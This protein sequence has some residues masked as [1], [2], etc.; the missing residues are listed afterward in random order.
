[1][2]STKITLGSTLLHVA[3]FTYV[4]TRRDP[5]LQTYGPKLITCRTHVQYSS[6]MTVNIMICMYD[7]LRR[8][9][10][11]LDTATSCYL[12]GRIHTDSTLSWQ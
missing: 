8:S 2:Y 12:I 3:L 1:M 7:F 4:F 9:P 6:F 11:A 5:I 10:R